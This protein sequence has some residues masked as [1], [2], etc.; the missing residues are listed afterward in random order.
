MLNKTK[1]S[2]AV[3]SAIVSSTP[4]IAVS[5]E[6][7]DGFVEGS[8]FN[9]LNRNFYM[10]RDFRKGQSSNTGNGYT[11]AWAH[12]I[13]GQF[14]SGFTQGTVGFGI[15]TFAMLGLK[16]DTGDGRYGPGGSV[17]LLPVNSEG[18]AEDNYSKVG[19]AV[20]VR[21]LDTVVKAGD[22]FPM[23]PV[24]HYGDSRLLPE[25]FR[26]VTLENSSFEGLTLQGGRLHAMS[27]PQVSTMRDDF[28]TFYAGPVDSSWLAYFGGDYSVSD[29]LSFSL[30]SS[31]L[32]DVW[33]QYYA[34][35]AFSRPLTDDISLFGGLNYYKAVDEGQQQLGEFNNNIYSGKV[36]VQ[37]GAHSVALSYQRN[38][39]DND[40]DYL[41]QSD[42][43][44]LDNSIQ[45]SDFNSPN[46]RSWMLR[47]DL[48]MASYGI[49][50]LSF[51]TR[52]AQGSDADY[53][54]ANEVYMR[55][56]DDGNPL[57][58]QKRWERDIEAKYVLQTGSLKDMSFRVRQMTTRATA[59]ESDLDEVRL[60]V[61][62]P[63]SVL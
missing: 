3:F 7:A 6:Q 53:S 56:D 26:G 42:S 15:D 48:D 57:T 44:Y 54:S 29:N 1:I 60:I 12:G 27:Q 41:R 36:G 39:G 9:I 58:D 38:N 5:E 55:R 40:F 11:E 10:N 34:G 16:L 20:K 14:E 8:S 23:T 47:Y 22:V 17:N 30:Y 4:L 37:F 51:M 49:P 63:L 21:L 50:G 19:G 2:L 13:I 32:K 33:D 18:E 62:Y 28:E 52:Y 43:I 46:E 45:Y 59:Y 35:T 25:S 61:E 24:V 31:K